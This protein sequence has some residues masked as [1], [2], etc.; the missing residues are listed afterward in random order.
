[1]KLNASGRAS[2]IPA[3]MTIFQAWTVRDAK[4]VRLDSY[5][6]R[7]EALEAAGV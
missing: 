3:E 5:L 7:E 1:L 2:G 6:S 4:L